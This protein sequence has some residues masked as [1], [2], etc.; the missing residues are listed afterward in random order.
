M[1]ESL[2]LARV[3]A[4]GGIRTI[5]A[6]PHVSREWDNGARSIATLCEEVTDQLTA[7]GIPLEVR[8]GAE[9]S[10]NR[11]AELRADEL[12][13]LGLG[14][15]PW[16]LVECPHHAHAVDVEEELLTL[17]TRGHRVVLAHPERC[18]A[19]QRD[20]DMLARLIAA[21]MIASVTAG[22]LTG[23][24][25]RDVRRFALELVRRELVH[26]VAS[27]AHDSLRRPPSIASELA[28]AGL[29]ELGDWA[30]GSVPAAVLAGASLP[31][32]PPVG[33]PPQ[34]GRWWQPRVR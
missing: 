31:P 27:D 18:P 21:G 8:P 7:H 6:T 2:N 3:A 16:L 29:D 32:R 9:I 10:L 22:A 26:N 34:G 11:A 30:S 14:G 1:E 25:G 28:E 15:G 33:G 17:G 4:A 19:F 24:F 5:V 23:R 20:P 13:A 12:A